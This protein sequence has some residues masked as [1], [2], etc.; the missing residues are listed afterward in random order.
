MHL[1]KFN[2]SPKPHAS[3]AKDAK[4]ANYQRFTCS[5][6]INFDFNWLINILIGTNNKEIQNTFSFEFNC[7]MCFLLNWLTNDFYTIA[8]L[9]WYFAL[10][11]FPFAC[12]N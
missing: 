11:A 7:K 2:R 10:F 3:H 8:F 5:E 1:I 9:R 4:D 12:D 6:E